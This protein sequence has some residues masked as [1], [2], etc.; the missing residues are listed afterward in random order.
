M[1]SV[2]RVDSCSRCLR[3]QMGRVAQSGRDRP[4]TGASGSSSF[5]WLAPVLDVGPVWQAL[6][7]RC[8]GLLFVCR[9][10][11][12]NL[13]T[14]PQVQGC[15]CVLGRGG[16]RQQSPRCT[17]QDRRSAPLTRLLPS[18]G[19]GARDRGS[20]SPEPVHHARRTAASPSPIPQPHLGVGGL[21]VPREHLLNVKCYSM[22]VIHD[23]S[24]LS[25]ALCGAEDGNRP[26]HG[27]LPSPASAL[28][29]QAPAAKGEPK[30]GVCT[31]HC[32][33]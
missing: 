32:I 27:R 12:P 5:K 22:L 2:S 23:T 31:S 11:A 3:L 15:G 13:R 24:N 1:L 8:Y 14:G 19:A 18:V 28:L 17:S 33:I 9:A 26:A 29:R 10:A 30:Y 21:E 6:Q 25:A 16:L 7:H 20:C 4:R